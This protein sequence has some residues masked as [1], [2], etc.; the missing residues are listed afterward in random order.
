MVKNLPTNAGE[1]QVQSLGQ[2]DAPEKGMATYSNIRAWGMPQRRSGVPQEE[3]GG[4]H[5]LRLAGGMGPS[6]FPGEITETSARLGQEVQGCYSER[7]VP[8]LIYLSRAEITRP[9]GSVE[10]PRVNSKNDQ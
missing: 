9:E 7:E 3:R 2:E 4:G 10:D 5:D 6:R 8:S 1:T